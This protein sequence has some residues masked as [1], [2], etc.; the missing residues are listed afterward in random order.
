MKNRLAF[1]IAAVFVTGF[2]FFNSMQTADVSSRES[3]VIVELLE[4]LLSLFDCVP[5]E[6]E[7]I[8]IVRKCAHVAEFALQGLLIAFCFNVP[9]KKRIIYILFSGLMTACID[10]YIQ[11][12]SNGR[13]AMVQD[14]FI[15]FAGTLLG[16]LT[17][18]LIL[19]IRHKLNRKG[20][21]K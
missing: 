1:I 16:M 4:R 20:E 18:W 13:A 9:F 2:I 8:H 6:G 5:N 14:I 7:L 12:F 10:E 3:G 21:Y 17:T 15:D 11:L 19:G